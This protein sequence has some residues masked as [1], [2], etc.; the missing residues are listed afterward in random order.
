VFG[1]VV[2]ADGLSIGLSPLTRFAAQIDLSPL[3]RGAL[4]A[5]TDRVKNNQ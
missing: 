5:R 3:G 1:L 2:G 4:S